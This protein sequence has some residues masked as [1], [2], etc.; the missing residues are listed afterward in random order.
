MLGSKRVWRTNEV[1]AS[2]K[3]A[4]KKDVEDFLDSLAGIGVLVAYGATEKDLRWGPPV[5][6]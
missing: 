1:A 2:F 4:K 5:V 6:R 3:G